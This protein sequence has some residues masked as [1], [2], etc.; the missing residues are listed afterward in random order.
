MIRERFKCDE[1]S[2]WIKFALRFRKPTITYDLE[3]SE[4]TYY[5]ITKR[6]FGKIYVIGSGYV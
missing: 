5:V 6:L 3:G 2:W 4:G 1:A